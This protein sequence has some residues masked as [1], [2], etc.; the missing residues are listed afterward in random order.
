MKHVGLLAVAA[1]ACVGI[2][3]LWSTTPPDASTVQSDGASAPV[4]QRGDKDSSSASAKYVAAIALASN[5]QDSHNPLAS[6]VPKP[7]VEGR[8]ELDRIF[9][10]GVP[11]TARSALAARALLNAGLSNDEKIALAR[12][13]G[14]LYAADN[15]TGHNADILLDLRSLV[16]DENKEV[17]RS[18]ALSFSR[19]GYLPGSDALLKTAFE[20]K[21]LDADDYYGEL[22]HMAPLAPAG[23]QD[24]LLSTMRASA[25]AY[26]ADILAGSINDDPK[27]LDRYSAH[28]V[29]ELG[30]LIGQSEPRFA[31]ATGD[32]GLTDAVRYAAWLRATAQIESRA[33]GGDVDAAI[34]SRLSMP[35]IDPRKITAYLLMPEA[36]SMLSSA[37]IGSPAGGL[38]SASHQYAAQHPGSKGLQSAAQEIGRRVGRSQG[39][40]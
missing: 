25:N 2:L 40:S 18:A 28:A 21:V 23:V 38:V 27:I 11:L 14:R 9:V 7:G 30:Q 10:Q 26:A 37:R 20:A 8:I 15:P 3:S 19:V 33:S 4:R 17:A 13:L 31:S 16:G 29:S 1:I 36:S 12:I 35:G 34:I 39:K 5:A 22:A 24:E 32:F 6:Y